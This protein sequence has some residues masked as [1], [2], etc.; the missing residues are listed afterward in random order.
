MAL[1]SLFFLLAAS[2]SLEETG[3]VFSKRSGSLGRWA[4]WDAIT[5]GFAV[6]ERSRKNQIRMRRMVLF[7]QATGT[8]ADVVPESISSTACVLYRLY[9]MT[10]SFLT[11]AY[12]AAH[13]GSGCNGCNKACG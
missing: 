4:L 11:M 8:G 12:P 2:N 9:G 5:R 10:I 1:R 6:Q 7:S 3:S 13:G